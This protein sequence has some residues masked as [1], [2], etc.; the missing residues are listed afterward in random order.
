MLTHEL[1]DKTEI[2]LIDIIVEL[3]V[4]IVDMILQILWNSLNNS[5]GQRH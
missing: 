4:T 2:K 1:D 3:Y 5:E